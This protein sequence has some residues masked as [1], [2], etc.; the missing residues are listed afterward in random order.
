M[1]ADNIEYVQGKEFKVLSENHPIEADDEF[2]DYTP[3]T[4]GIKEKTLCLK[5]P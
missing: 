4:I 5:V 3:A 1:F 2:I